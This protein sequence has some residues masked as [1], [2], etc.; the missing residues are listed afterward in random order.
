MDAG[1]ISHFTQR[2]SAPASRV[3][4]FPIRYHSP[5]CAFQL[6]RALREIRPR[7][8]LIEAPADFSHLIPLLVD[9]E[10]RPPVAI[11]AMPWEKRPDGPAAV[12]Y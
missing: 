1:E 3:H 12:A 10:L 11:V 5:A 2:L 8:I 7:L 4:F 6:A 9:P